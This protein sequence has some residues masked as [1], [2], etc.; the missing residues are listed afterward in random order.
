MSSLAGYRYELDTELKVAHLFMDCP[1]LKMAKKYGYRQSK[2][3]HTVAEAGI[4]DVQGY[5][6]CHKC[7]KKEQH[8]SR[9]D[10][11]YPRPG[12]KREPRK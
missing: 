12:F 6:S 1:A 2:H 9:K 11:R 5:R 8:L 10:G 4:L 3:V 7:W